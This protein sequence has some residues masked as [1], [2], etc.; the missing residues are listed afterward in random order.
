MSL[1]T[2][3]YQK[4]KNEILHAVRGPG[5]VLYEADIA[6]SFGVSK[7]PVRESLLLLTEAGWIITLPRKGYIV[8]PVELRD[9]RDIFAF[10]QMIE[11]R[12]AGRATSL[13]T[14]R[15]KEELLGLVKMQAS[16]ELGRGL[17]AAREFHLN[18]ASIAGSPRATATL[19]DLVDE[20]LR[21]HYLLPMGEE[22]ITSAEELRAHEDIL[23]AI[24]AGDS[25]KAEILMSSHL[26]EVA[27][28][29]VKGFTGT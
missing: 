29:L 11:P 14:E 27:Q 10:R 25:D 2:E 18:L 17:I 7:T 9:V 16:G 3:V 15:Q 19:T 28:T 8:R 13:A 24:C 26:A 4:L 12:L 20:V 5:D 22:H 21:L 1:T 6:K 23:A